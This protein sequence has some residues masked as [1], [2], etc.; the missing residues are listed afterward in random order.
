MTP[1]ELEHL[2]KLCDRISREFARG[3]EVVIKPSELALAAFAAA[4]NLAARELKRI[5]NSKG[6][7][8]K[9]GEYSTGVHAS[10][11]RHYRKHGTYKGWQE[12]QNQ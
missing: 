6:P 8:K 1:K 4:N 11:M 3:R 9:P 2:Q 7:R 12:S 10:R 5:A